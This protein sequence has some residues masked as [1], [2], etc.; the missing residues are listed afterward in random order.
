MGQPEEA[1]N[2]IA[3]LVSDDASF[4]TGAMLEVSGGWNM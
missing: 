1:A 3:F 4:M 2:V